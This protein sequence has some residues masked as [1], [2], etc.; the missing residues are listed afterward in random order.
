MLVTIV[1][2]IYNME[3][4]LPR[5]MAGLLNQTYQDIEIL[6]IDDGS[7][8]GS[9]K[10]CEKYAHD[11]PDKIFIIH[12]ENGGL[13]SARNAGIEVA[14]GKYIIFPD[15]DDWV[16]PG[17]IEAL[18]SAQEE[19]NADLVCLGHYINYDNKELKANDGQVEIMLN[20]IDAKKALFVQPC[21][22]GFAWNKL[23]HL[24]II[25]ENSLRF[26]DDV[27]T[28]E[29]LDFAFRYL[30]Y[31]KSVYFNPTKRIYHYYQRSDAATGE[32]FSKKKVEAI[33]TY[34]KIIQ[35]SCNYPEIIKAA[36]EEIC[37]IAINLTWLYKRNHCDD[38]E[39]WKQIRKYLR[40]YLW[41]YLKSK[42]F[43]VGRKIQAVVAWVSPS[44]YVILKENVRDS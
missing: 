24:D 4:F 21:M 2:P 13:S 6:L 12:K 33:R 10:L 23:Y 17:Y 9:L 40:K 27:G 29:D 32:R 36:K 7:T 5:C 25:R 35:A 1:V 44:L 19:T 43:N 26:L 3:Q 15:P 38:I 11:Y 31:C 14:R 8:D 22:S 20:A 37:N 30:D 39:S 18:L 41:C 42:K 28:T 16:E 34:E